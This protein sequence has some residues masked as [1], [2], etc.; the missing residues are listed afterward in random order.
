MSRHEEY[1]S[2]N[3]NF[4]N[5]NLTTEG[6]SKEENEKL[7]KTIKNKFKI[8]SIRIFGKQKCWFL[9]GIKPEEEKR[10]IE[11]VGIEEGYE[12]KIEK[13]IKIFEKLIKPYLGR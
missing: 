1:M 6:Y 3:E 12:I 10:G 2:K 8:S 4:I 7:S 11:C 13:E 9:L 5:H